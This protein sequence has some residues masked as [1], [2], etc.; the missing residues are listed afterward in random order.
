MQL[1][2]LLAL[3]FTLLGISVVTCFAAPGGAGPKRPAS[4]AVVELFTSEGC[5]SCPPADALS[6]EINLKETSAGQLICGHQRTR[7]VLE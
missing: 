6:R 5:S 4:V 1:R 2:S 3:S 7:N